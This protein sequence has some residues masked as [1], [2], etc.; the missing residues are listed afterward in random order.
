MTTF[1][2]RFVTIN[3]SVLI[4]VNLQKN[5]HIVYLK[6]YQLI[7][8]CNIT[9]SSENLPVSTNFS[10]LSRLLNLAEKRTVPLQLIKFLIDQ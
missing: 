5:T 4:V 3:Q 7:V 9:S 10:L 8:A 6:S 1:L 2:I